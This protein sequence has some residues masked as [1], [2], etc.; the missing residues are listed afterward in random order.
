MVVLYGTASFFGA[1]LLFLV[2]PMLA[3]LVLP[4]FGGS[5]TVWNTCAL[6][7]QALLLAGYLY[8]H[9]TT[10]RLGP[11]RQPW[12]HLVL[13]VLPLLV[14]PVALPD[15][16][17]P[18]PGTEP[19]LWLLR[20]LL[21]AVG[22]PF[23]LLATTGPLLQRWFSWSGH[24]RAQDPYFLYAASNAGSVVGLLGY[25]FVIEP[26]VGLAAQ[27]QWWSIAYGGFLLLVGTCGVLAGRAGRRGPVAESEPAAYRAS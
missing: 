11:R 14:L 20:V 23:L 15:D 16:P 13:L 5:P 12:V 18:D 1:A 26:T 19:A 21:V 27:T 9:L 25:P 7:F 24:P 22:L 10:R 4:Y 6:F 2:Q 8:A 3:K 17:A